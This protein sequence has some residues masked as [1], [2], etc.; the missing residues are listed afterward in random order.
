MEF[1]FHLSDNMLVG[2]SFLAAVWIIIMSAVLYTLYHAWSVR[3]WFARH[4]R[5]SLTT[6]G[7]IVSCKSY[8]D[9]SNVSYRFTD[10]EGDEIN[11]AMSIDCL[12][13][14]GFA[15]GEKIRVTY[16][17]ENPSLSYIEPYRSQYYKSATGVTWFMCAMMCFMIFLVWKTVF[18]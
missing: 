5:L 2:Y 14:S 18:G 12:P 6:D 8:D 16:C 11:S 13:Q 10:K 9:S 7:E 17:R 4:E 1:S 3:G 15:E